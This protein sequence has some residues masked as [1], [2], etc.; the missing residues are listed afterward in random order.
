MSLENI[1]NKSWKDFKSNWKLSLKASFWFLILPA[2]V[3]TLILSIIGAGIW[4]SY[5][6]S[7]ENLQNSTDFLR[8]TGNAVNDSLQ[9]TSTLVGLLSF[10]ILGAVVLIIFYYFFH[11][12]ITYISVYNEKGKISFKDASRNCRKYFWKFL[13]LI[14][15]LIVIIY[16]A[17]LVP[18]GIGILFLVLFREVLVLGILILV[19]L[20]ICGFVLMTYLSV[21]L[22]F[23]PYILLR[24]NKG[25][26]ESFKISSRLVKGKWWKSFGYLILFSLVIMGLSSV[27]SMG[28]QVIYSIFPI[29]FLL[30]TLAGPF[31]IAAL[32]FLVFAIIIILYSLSIALS[33][34][35][36]SLLI[37]NSY[38]E[39]RAG[40]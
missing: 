7:P 25:V 29:L 10:I 3:F 11:L 39:F 22:I 28:M 17:L 27:V 6:R 20:V 18:I 9:N 19:L 35:V 37:K 14:F 15:L 31:W 23:S 24:E 36:A 33:S 30:S 5:I 21:R 16:V 32:L 2:I 8:M 40:R 12:F 38:L 13:W 1:F 26:I 4:S 34:L